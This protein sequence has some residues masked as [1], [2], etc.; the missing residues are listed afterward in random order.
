MTG[1]RRPRW[2]RAIAISFAVYP[3]VALSGCVCLRFLQLKNQFSRFDEHFQLTTDSGLQLR[4]LHPILLTSD[5]RWLGFESANV[6]QRRTTEHWYLRW[7][8]QPSA[9]A[10]GDGPFEIAFDLASPGTGF[11]A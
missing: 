6:N 2:R 10:P 8:K 5:L 9:G 3:A 11:R 7:V 4:F 1:L